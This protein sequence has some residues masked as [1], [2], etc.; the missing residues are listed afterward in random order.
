MSAR[1]TAFVALG[2]NLGER[3]RNLERALAALGRRGVPTLRRSSLYLTEPVG[4]PP[5]DDF[6]NAVAEVATDLAPEELLEACLAVEREMGR[7]RAERNGPR[8]IDLDLLLVGSAV[9]QGPRLVL[10]HPRMAERRFVLVPLCEIAPQALHPGLG[11][12]VEEILAR[13]PDRSRVAPFAPAA[14]R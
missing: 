1:E 7:V 12:T 13:C 2:S 14:A 6:L 11:L 8:L 10:P 5:Q 4:G 9:R 3:E